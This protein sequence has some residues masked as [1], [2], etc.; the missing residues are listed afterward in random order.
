MLCFH[1]TLKM[2]FL[3]I[4]QSLQKNTCAGTFS[5]KVAGN[6]PATLLKERLLATKSLCARVNKRATSFAYHVIHRV[7]MYMV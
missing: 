6:Q 7:K 5:T 2:V 4:P 3:K 1:G